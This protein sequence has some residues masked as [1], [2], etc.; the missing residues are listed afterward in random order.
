VLRR[1]LRQTWK[2][3]DKHRVTDLAAMLT[4]YAIFALFP[5]A[6]FTVTLT[7]LFMPADVL[8]DAFELMAITLPGPVSQL[9]I[10][11]LSRMEQA[12]AGGFAIGAAALAVWGASRGAVALQTALNQIHE[13]KETRPWWKVQL[14]AIATTIGVSILILVALALLLVG[15][16]VGRTLAERFYLGQVFDVAWTV[17]RWIGAALIMMLVWACLYY[18]LPDIRR[19]FRWVTPGA[20][21]GVVL[22]LAASRGF[23][24]YVDNFASYDKSYG[25]LGTI[26][27]FLTWLWISSLALLIGG[28]IDDAIDELRKEKEPAGEVPVRHREGT[29][30]FPVTPDVGRK[31]IEEDPMDRHDDRVLV[32]ARPGAVAPRDQGLGLAELV[33]RVGDDFGHLAR[34]HAELA[35][36]ELTSGV[37]RAAGEAAAVILGGVV[38]LIGLGLLCVS[39]VVAAAPL[40]PPLWLRLVLGA[41]LYMG[42]G[43]LAV[44]V[45]A[46]R[47]RQEKPLTLEKTRDEVGRT[48]TVLKEQI[49]NG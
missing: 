25:A 48:A 7:L 10:E 37:K 1:I 16:T 5:F 40:V 47:L 6:I 22:W 42:L 28:E 33:K 23:I 30:P 12:A 36:A 20:I 35:R 21:A 31:T 3:I 46:R 27:V 29:A 44:F 14:I 11:H 49:Q 2:G 39:A 19:R 38:A 13:V 8:H 32:R 43:A 34:S 18:F 41:M 17:G 9:A 26:I 45:F 15:P 24:L 4:Y